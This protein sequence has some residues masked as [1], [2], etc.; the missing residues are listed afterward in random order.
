MDAYFE[1]LAFAD[2]NIQQAWFLSPVTDMVRII[3]HLMDY[4][5]ASEA[6]FAKRLK[7]END[8]ETLYYPYYVYV[9]EHP[10]VQW[11]HPTAIQ[12]GEQDQL[13]EHEVV[14]QFVDPFGC[15]LTIQKDGE[16]WFHAP[17][18]LAFYREWLK[19]HL[20]FFRH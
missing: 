12:R 13:Y 14:K 2:Q 15:D 1:L 20:S 6:D 16:H 3:D 9:K 8:V 10:I 4:C 7:I 11:P 17:E 19:R 18:E 5:Q